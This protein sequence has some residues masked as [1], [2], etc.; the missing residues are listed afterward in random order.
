M[1]SA[2]ICESGMECLWR[3]G[4]RRGQENICSTVMRGGGIIEAVRTGQGKEAGEEVG[5]R[6]A[7]VADA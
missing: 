7:S 4:A 1:D 5:V 2:K 6:E 3:S